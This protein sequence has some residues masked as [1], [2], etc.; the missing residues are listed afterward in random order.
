[1][2]TATYPITGN[3]Y[4]HLDKGQ[5]FFVVV[6]N[7]DTRTVEI[8]HFDG[9]VDEFDFATWCQLDI[10]PCEAPENW[11]GPFDIDHSDD[12]GTE[13]TDTQ[14]SDWDAPLNEFE[15]KKQ[16]SSEE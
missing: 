7:E 1:M 3:W 5:R 12:L 14:P 16:N 15:S 4:C 13:I 8:Q 9:N 2:S 6:V 10:E 11:S